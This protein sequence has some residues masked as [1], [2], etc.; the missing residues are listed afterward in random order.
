[1]TVLTQDDFKNLGRLELAVHGDSLE[2][3]YWPSV[4]AAVPSYESFWRSF[5]VLLTN[6]VNPL[7]IEDWIRVRQG[8]PENYE[9]LLM[10]NYTVFYDLV[11]ARA[12]I[13]A[14][15]QALSQGA[16][17]HAE[18]FF[19]YARACIENLKDLLSRARRLLAAADIRMR[20]PGVPDDVMKEIKRYRDT[21][22]HKP[23]LGRAIKDGRD[24]VL[25]PHLLPQ[26]EGEPVLTWNDTA[27]R[28]DKPMTDIVELQTNQWNSLAKSLKKTWEAMTV[29]FE[30]FRVTDGFIQ[31]ADVARFLPIHPSI[32]STAIPS[33]H[34]P[35]GASGLQ[36]YNED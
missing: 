3:F 18:P 1:M 11:V 34:N 7:A 35:A 24:M 36:I 14:G 17:Y 28:T 31:A 5:I 4:A 23:V 27:A 29:G 8:I 9:R 32:G 13:E 33:F 19:F 30:E 2:R 16:F 21:Y 20:I 10:A 25:K 12:E 6:R 26:S 15:K 22:M